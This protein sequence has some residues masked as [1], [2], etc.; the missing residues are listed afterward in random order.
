VPDVVVA[1]HEDHVTRRDAGPDGDRRDRIGARDF[2]DDVVQLEHG[3]EQRARVHTD[4]HGAVAE[5]LGDPD[6]ATRTDEPEK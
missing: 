4:E 2:V 1:L 3:L 6:A 5:P